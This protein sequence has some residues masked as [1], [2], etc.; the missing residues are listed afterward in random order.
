MSVSV[1]HGVHGLDR[2]GQAAANCED[3]ARRLTRRADVR[4][5]MILSTCNRVEIYL[6]T[7]AGSDP[8]Q[9]ALAV[10]NSLFPADSVGSHSCPVHSRANVLVGKGA[11][12]H[13]FEVASGLDSMVVG[14][15]EISGQLRRAHVVATREHT[16]STD[17]SRAVEAA[18][19]TSRNVA[20]L[21]GL[22]GTGRSV[23]AVALSLVAPI[24]QE[25]PASVNALIIG[26]GSYA[27]ASVAQLR[28][29]QIENIACYSSSGRAERF[30][31]GHDVT[32]IA[33]D[34]LVD[35]L[36]KADLVISCRGLGAPILNA[37]LVSAAQKQ[38]QAS[39]T[40]LDMALT[41]DVAEDVRQVSGVRVLS[42]RDVQEQIPEAA[43]GHIEKAHAL[44]QKAV[45]T[46]FAE[47]ESRRMDPVV[48]ALR[49]H[50]WHILD[51]EIARLPHRNQMSRE[52]AAA[53][54]HHFASRLAHVPSVN[55]RLAATRG[56]DYEYVRALHAVMGIDLAEAAVEADVKPKKMANYCPLAEL[57]EETA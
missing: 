44:V 37:Q 18:L 1:H 29:R 24:W 38:R 40:I 2:V 8:A 23:V 53:A 7:E 35:A 19:H 48:V 27:G 5:A 52:D 11:L 57:R 39:Q 6:D 50:I 46:A 4:G 15:R 17:L 12:T 13:L 34:G 22:A 51:E 42:L 28:G 36:A 21:T 55:A 54:L 41:G 16:T 30:A 3:L 45:E 31:K 26:T 43:V 25:D 20:R 14:E 49:E 33:A 56:S 47:I 9:V 32:P 10:V